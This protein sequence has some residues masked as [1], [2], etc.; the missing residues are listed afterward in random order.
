MHVLTEQPEDQLQKQNELHKYTQVT[1]E[2]EN[3][4]TSK[5]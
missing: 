1:D 2:S 5:N 3:N 4:T